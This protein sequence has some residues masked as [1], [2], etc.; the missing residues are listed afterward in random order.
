MVKSAAVKTTAPATAVI[1]AFATKMP[2]AIQNGHS[3]L[4]SVRLT[5]L[6]FAYE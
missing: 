1:A 6:L 5:G 3:P 2:A 4:G